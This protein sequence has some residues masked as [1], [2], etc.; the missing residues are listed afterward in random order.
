MQSEQAEYSDLFK[1]PPSAESRM[2]DKL[3][4]L[5]KSKEGL[6]SKQVSQEICEEAVKIFHA[7]TIPEALRQKLGPKIAAFQMGFCDTFVTEV[8]Q[9]VLE[10]K[11]SLPE[12]LPIMIT[13][14]RLM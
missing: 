5:I 11:A 7:K 1:R 4:E 3:L 10:Y 14:M 12:P 9:V 8:K 6:A 13:A 2:I